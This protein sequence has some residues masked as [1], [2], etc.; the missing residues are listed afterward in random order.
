MSQ[1]KSYKL[2]EDTE[3]KLQEL[4]DELKKTDP[5]AT[6]ETCF[7]AMIRAYKGQAAAQAAGRTEEAADFHAL[8]SRIEESYNSILAG[9][10]SAKERAEAQ[11]Q[12]EIENIKKKMEAA[13]AASSAA[14]EIEEENKALKK[15]IE[16]AKKRAEEAA[17]ERDE[18]RGINKRLIS[19]IEKA[20]AELDG[21]EDI[22]KKAA[23]I[24]AAAETI[25]ALQEETKIKDSKIEEYEKRLQDEEAKYKEL[26]SELKGRYNEKLETQAAAAANEAKEARLDE[27][28]KLMK[29]MDAMRAEFALKLAE[30]A[31]AT[32]QQDGRGKK[33]ILT[34]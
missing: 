9:I 27:R 24:D 7:A 20:E 18:T 26:A 30:V 4:M 6:W 29:E 10:V 8:L 31:A 5:S 15:E 32:K 2:H 17:A 3:T 19:E 16:D 22:K 28:E 25:K 23:S 11:A 14:R 13:E 33:N 12:S 21:I 34:A 1:P